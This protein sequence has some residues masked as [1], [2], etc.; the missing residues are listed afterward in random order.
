M[1]ERDLLFKNRMNRA[2]GKP[3]DFDCNYNLIVLHDPHSSDSFFHS[4]FKENTLSSS[5]YQLLILILFFFVIILDGE[6]EEMISALI[7]LEKA[8][9]RRDDRFRF[10]SIQK[11]QKKML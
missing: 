9:E 10:K 2:I 11:K 8:A 5:V 7:L 6:K 4:E 3:S 1:V